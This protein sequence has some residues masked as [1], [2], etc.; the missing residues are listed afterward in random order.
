[1]KYHIEL[2]VALSLT[3]TT[4]IQF[5]VS[6]PCSVKRWLSTSAKSINPCQP[7]QSE[8]ASMGQNSLLFGK[9]SALPFPKQALFFTLL[10]YKYFENTVGKGEIARDE[11]FLLFPQ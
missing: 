8:Q 6:Y 3:N 2:T 4:K 10:L 5:K 11:Q 9:F 1:M 7:V